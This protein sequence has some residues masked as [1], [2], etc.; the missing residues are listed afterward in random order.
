MLN[1][2]CVK[3][4]TKYSSVLVNRL[5]KMC[6]KNITQPFKFFCYTENAEGIDAVVNIIP[7]VDH[8]LDVIMHNKLFLFSEHID[9]YLTNGDRM[10]FDLD[11]IIKGNIDD[12]VACNKGE[13][14]LIRS[15]WRKERPRTFLRCDHMFNSSCMTW[16]SPH[17]RK[18][19]EHFNGDIEWFS[20]RY[21]LGMD[22]FLSYEEKN[23]GTKI[24]FF[25]SRKF[26]SY[27]YGIDYAEETW[28]DETYGMPFTLKFPK[29]IESIPVVLLNG[30]T[31][32]SDYR[33]FKQYYE[34]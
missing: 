22:S 33:R 7:F 30:D 16:K 21:H 1:V 31:T 25:P 11:M 10:Y 19:W 27:L 6:K 2:L 28:S 9:S 12:I 13:L 34:D 26:Y 8:G 17:T 29:S 32:E 4:G 15:E 20:L 23:I 14:T 3:I 18:I 5:Y 24:H